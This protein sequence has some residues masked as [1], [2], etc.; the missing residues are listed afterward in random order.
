MTDDP[1]TH[2]YLCRAWRGRDSLRG[3]VS[4]DE[5]REQRFLERC[6]NWKHVIPEIPLTTSVPVF[7]PDPHRP[8][9]SRKRIVVDT[10]DEGRL[11]S[12]G[13]GGVDTGPSLL[14]RGLALHPKKEAAQYRVDLDHPQGFGYALR[15]LHAAA[16]A[17][18]HRDHPMPTETA[19]KLHTTVNEL[20]PRWV[21]GET[22]PE[23]RL[24]LT[25]SLL[26]ALWS[27]ENND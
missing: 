1:T 27:S 12:L 23:D 16:D 8:H 22:T 9:L 26:S 20:T 25:A 10:H 4:L 18:L 17:G 19:D 3:L 24:A 14:G 6:D 7:Y 11:V 5:A 15:W 13:L 2:P 21:A